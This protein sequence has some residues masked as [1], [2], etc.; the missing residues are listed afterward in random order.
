MEI[1]INY[2]FELFTFFPTA[3]KKTVHVNFESYTESEWAIIL[4]QNILE[5]FL[6]R[7]EIAVKIQ[8]PR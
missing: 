4:P 7:C 1:L 6:A 5:Q 2:I 3:A 8:H